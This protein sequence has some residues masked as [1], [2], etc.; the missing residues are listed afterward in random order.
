L[1]GKI[2][3]YEHKNKNDKAPDNRGSSKRM[4]HLQKSDLSSC[5]RWEIETDNWIQIMDV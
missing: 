4:E 3:T 5:E 2:G 1:S